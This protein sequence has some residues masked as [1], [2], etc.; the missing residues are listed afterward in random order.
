MQ[1]E[2]VFF[3][4]GGERCAAWL[5][6][7]DGA[8]DAPC[9]VMAHGFS[10]TRHEALDVFAERFAR[11]G[12]AALVFDHRFLG[13]SGG[14]PRQRFR[15]GEQLE[16]WR[17]AVAY[18][19]ALDG[20]DPDRIVL[21]GFSMAGG[22]AVTL[23]AG[24]PRVAAALVVCPLVNGLARTLKTPPRLVGWILPRAM[25]DM[26]GRHNLVRVTAQPGEMAAMTLPGEADGFART[27][28]AGS[29]WRNEISPGVFTKI[30][31]HRPLAKAGRVACPLWVG[32]GERDITVDRASVGEL[33]RYPYDHFDPFVGDAPAR[34]ADDQVAFLARAGLAREPVAA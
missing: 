25:A 7:P 10:L 13:D 21:W 14:L 17:N 5:Y 24:D 6:R 18:A 12:V 22:H 15:I 34:I 9:V 20:V 29:P 8:A 2:D 23:A 32:L 28:A 16:D 27:V 4:S 26:A 19:R 3:T 31:T 33:H 11:A 30:A 1:R